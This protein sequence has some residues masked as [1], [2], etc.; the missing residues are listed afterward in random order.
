MVIVMIASPAIQAQNS[1]NLS[2]SEKEDKL[3]NPTDPMWNKWLMW[4]LGYQR[5]IERNA[6]YIELENPA[7]STSSITEFHITIGDNNFNFGPVD[8]S[9]LIKLGSTTPGFNLSATTLN[10]AGD[11]LVVTIGNGG[12]LPNSKVRFEIKLD[13]DPAYA[14]TYQS[15][16]GDSR[17]DFRTVLFDMNGIDVYAGTTTP[18]TL[19]NSQAFVNFN[20]GGKSTVATFEDET[21]PDGQYFNNNIREYKAVDAVLIFQLEGAQIP[22][23]TS[24]GLMLLGF[25][26]FCVGSRRRSAVA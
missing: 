14:A 25:A 12:L 11:E 21:V 24:I 18:S 5:M 17:P 8:G 23:P 22:E 6:P 4:D 19:D 7:T 13:V 15:L 20:P 2:I 16:F 10:G 3:A 26:G 1:W 9:N